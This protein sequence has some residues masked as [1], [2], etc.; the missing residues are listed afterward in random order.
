M[1]CDEGNHDWI[2]MRTLSSRKNLQYRSRAA[3]YFF[4]MYVSLAAR[5]HQLQPAFL[6]GWFAASTAILLVL[7]VFHSDTFC[8]L[9]GWSVPLRFIESAAST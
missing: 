5:T 8:W 7:R 4:R 2:M 1:R 9:G 3:L 6:F